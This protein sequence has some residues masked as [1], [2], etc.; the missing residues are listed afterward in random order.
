MNYSVERLENSKYA[1]VPGLASLN[2]F[3]TNA[4]K[5]HLKYIFSNDE[6]YDPVLHYTGW[7]PVTRLNNGIN[8]WEKPDISPLPEVRPRRDLPRYQRLMWGTLPIGALGLGLLTLLGLALTQNLISSNSHPFVRERTEANDYSASTRMV[9]VTRTIPLIVSLAV[10]LLAGL[11][12][13]D[14]HKP[15]S[16]EDTIK[17]FYQHL[18]FRETGKAYALLKPSADIDYGQFLRIQKLTGGLVPS[19]GKLTAVTSQG[20]EFMDDETIRVYSKLTYLTS[21]GVRIVITDQTLNKSTDGAWLKPTDPVQRLARPKI[22]LMAAEFIERDGRMYV[23]GRLRNISQFPACAKIMAKTRSR[24]SPIVL[25][26]HSG[27]VGAHRLLP[28]EDSAFRIDFEGY[29]K[30]QDQAINAAYDPEQF[31]VAELD[32]LPSSVSLALSTTVCTPD[33]YKSLKFADINISEDDY[34]HALLNLRVSNEG[35]EIVSTLQVKLSYLDTD[36]RL[37]WVEPYYLQNN[38]IPGEERLVK[39][40]LAAL[41]K[42]SSVQTDRISINGKDKTI[43]KTSLWP[44]GVKLPDESGQIIIDYDAMIYRPLD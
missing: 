38:L 10:L 31:S 39:I 8:V 42:I 25:E 16:P 30:I 1:G 23:A 26:Q 21:V 43:S 12:V 17:Q 34:G 18:D 6:F 29:L 40:P 32:A 14:R 35:T 20:V 41:P 4:E 13:L 19:Y 5:F 36:G 37:V 9:L 33:Y 7:N 15:T 24:N 44:T 11:V 2:Q 28:G 27:R 3:L 22:K